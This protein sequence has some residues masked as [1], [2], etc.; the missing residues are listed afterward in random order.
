M[1]QLAFGIYEALIDESIRE[2]LA[3]RPELRSVF[4]KIDPEELPG[5]YASFV[6]KVLEQALREERN[7]EKRFELCNRILAQVAG[8]PGMSHMP[9]IALSKKKNRSFLRSLLQITLRQDFRA[10]SRPLL[11]AAF[12]PARPKNRSSPMNCSKR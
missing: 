10:L 5:L 6:A 7:P 4:G 2:A 9:S 1:K 3:S 11:K 8:E 12:L